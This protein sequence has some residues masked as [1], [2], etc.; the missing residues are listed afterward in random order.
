MTQRATLLTFRFPLLTLLLLASVPAAAQPLLF[1]FLSPNA[2]A[3]GLFGFSVA[4]VPDANGD[5]VADLLVGARNEAPGTSPNFAGRAYLFSGATGVLLHTLISPN[6]QFVGFF[7]SSVAGVP[8]ADGDGRGDLLVGAPDEM[9][10]RAYLFS[11]TTGALLFELVSPNEESGGPF[12]HSVSSVPDAD[13]DGRGDLLVGAFNEDPGV[14]PSGAGRAYLFSGATGAI[15]STLVSPNEE[16]NGNFG[17]SVAGVPDA[18]GDGRGDLLVGAYR[19]DPGPTNS[20][21]G[22]AY[23][24]SGATGTLLQSIDSP[25]PNFEGRFGFSVAGVPDTNGDGRGDLLIGA[26][27]EDPGTVPDETGRAYLFSG[28]TGTLLHTLA[29]PNEEQDGNFGY[30][31]ARVPDADGDGRGDLLIGA[32]NEDPGLSPAAAGRAYLFSGA[33]GTLLFELSSLNE[34][35]GGE[36]GFSVAGVPDTDGDGRGDLLV[37]ARDEGLGGRVYLFSGASGSGFNLTATNTSSLTVVPGGSVTFAY[38]VTNNTSNSASGDIFF[39]ARRNGVVVATGRIRSGA[40]PAGQ[41]ATG[42]FTQ[43]VPQGAPAG[44]YTYELHIGQFPSVIADTETF[45]VTVTGSARTSGVTAWTVTDAAPWEISEALVSTSRAVETT[46]AAYPNPFRQRTALSFT[47]LTPDRVRLAVYDVL[48]R[49]VAVLADGTLD[50]GS[51]E[52]T[53]DAAGLPSGVYLWR[54]EAGAEVQAGRLTLLR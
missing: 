14:S 46:V 42:T 44:T 18:D 49:E 19:E 39:V 33:S 20:A 51:H 10:G 15:L 2:E 11:G 27:G 40:L 50:A 6:E 7:G 9:G 16:T 47:L 3:I 30:S 23:L 12:G 13:G 48:G 1:E 41:T 4:S 17:Y 21:L 43:G 5:G 35:L 53:F 45:T 37:G 8:D 52:A 29:S 25:N 28:A 36:F 38:A 34:E 24:F 26:F 31:V 32:P 54:L 22:Q